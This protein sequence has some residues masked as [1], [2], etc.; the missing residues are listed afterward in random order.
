MGYTLVIFTKLHIGNHLLW[1][2]DGEKYE[3][4]LYLYIIKHRIP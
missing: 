3:K 4:K 2:G 1:S